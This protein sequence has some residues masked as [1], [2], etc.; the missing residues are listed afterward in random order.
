M[1]MTGS[2]LEQIASMN[3][4]MGTDNQNLYSP[5]VN[6]ALRKTQDAFMQ[7]KINNFE[8]FFDIKKLNNAAHSNLVVQQSQKDKSSRVELSLKQRLRA[9]KAK[10]LEQI[11]Q[12]SSKIESKRR[13]LAE[14]KEILD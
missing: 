14:D 11:S 9:K 6:Q 2:N 13:S 3:K 12:I 10:I 4:L 7:H 1:C 5:Y 8:Q